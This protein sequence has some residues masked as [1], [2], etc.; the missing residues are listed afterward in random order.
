MVEAVALVRDDKRNHT[1]GFQHIV[2]VV[3]EAGQIGEVLDHMARDDPVVAICP[4]DQLTEWFTPPDE[5]DVFDPGK[6]DIDV[7]ELLPQGV[8][9]D[10]VEDV[11]VESLT[12]GCDRAVRGAD[13]ES[14]T[15]PVDEG[16]GLLDSTE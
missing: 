8:G 12:P 3:E 9:I 7:L 13:L 16:Q 15:V 2:A 1:F 10:V 5:I 4:A 6:I 14:E 11:H